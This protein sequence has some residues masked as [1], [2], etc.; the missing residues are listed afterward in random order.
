MNEKKKAL[1]VTTVASTIDQFCSNDIA[2][3][4]KKYR[5]YVAANFS[6]GNN[7]TNRRIEEFKLE[8][9][10]RLWE[11]EDGDKCPETQIVYKTTS[12]LEEGA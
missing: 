8:I 5:V 6:S 3:L 4:Q 12:P 11:N 7:T 2:I 1:V 10:V 9:N